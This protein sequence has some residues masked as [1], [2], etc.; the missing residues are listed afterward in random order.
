MIFN[1][2]ETE[3]ESALWKA[4]PRGKK[5]ECILFKEKTQLSPTAS[6]P[7]EVQHRQKHFIVIF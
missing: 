4:S 5:R 3:K 6:L 2:T 7:Y 1:I